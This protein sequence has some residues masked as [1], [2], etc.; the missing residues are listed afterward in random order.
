MTDERSGAGLEPAQ[1]R[2]FGWYLA[3]AA[4]SVAAIAVIY[5]L[6]GMDALGATARFLWNG[7]VFAFNGLFRVLGSLL[8]VI[9]RGLGLR[10]VSRLSTVIGGVGLTY[11]GSAV[12]SDK[13]VR[14]AQG[15]RAKIRAAFIFLRDGWR[16]LPLIAKIL[17]VIVLIT[18]QVYLHAVLIVFPVAFLVPVVRRIWVQAADVALGGWYRRT[19]GPWHRRFMARLRR[20]PVVRGAIGAVRVTRIRYLCAWRLWR[21][22]PRYRSASARRKLSLIEPIRLWRR[23]ELDTYIGR[24]L[25][26]GREAKKDA[27]DAAG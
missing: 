7:V 17:V 27:S 13:G 5:L 1:R 26:S 21:Y 15:W 2:T 14:R 18:S 24:P 16:R 6:T 12:L 4:I 8:A 10:Q 23:G 25:L 11:A 22:H 9:A 3:F 20:L 19:F